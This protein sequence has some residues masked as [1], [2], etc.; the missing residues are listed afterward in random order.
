M[1]MGGGCLCLIYCESKGEPNFRLE[2]RDEKGQVEDKEYLLL[3]VRIEDVQ[4]N[5]SRN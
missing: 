1:S 3:E 2:K 5:K 4:K